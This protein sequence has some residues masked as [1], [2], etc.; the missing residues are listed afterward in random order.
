[1]TF[2]C[3]GSNDSKDVW[4]VTYSFIALKLLS[5]Y[6]EYGIVSTGLSSLAALSDLYE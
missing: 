5:L 6:S 1:M 4:T 2:A 3:A